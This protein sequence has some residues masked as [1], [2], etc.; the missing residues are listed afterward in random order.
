ISAGECFGA[1]G[2]DVVHAGKLHAFVARQHAGMNSGNIA[3]THDS[4]SEL[5]HV[6]ASA[7]T[8]LVAACASRASANGS[9]SQYSERKISTLAT[10]SYPI[11]LKAP[12]ICLSGRIPS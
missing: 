9:R 8:R 5:V 6:D 2:N 1:T 10:L 11:F 4:D 12:I 3:R 7:S